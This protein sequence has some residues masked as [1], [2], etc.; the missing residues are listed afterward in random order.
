MKRIRPSID[1]AEYPAFRWAW[2]ATLIVG[3][4][5]ALGM[6]LIYR[7]PLFASAAGLIIGVIA[8]ALGLLL[9]FVY[10]HPASHTRPSDP[11]G[12]SPNLSPRR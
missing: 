9:G 4:I 3:L 6:L 2:R 11:E 10:A 7:D 5:T 8:G 1:A 12:R